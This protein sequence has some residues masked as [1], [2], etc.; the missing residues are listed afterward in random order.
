MANAT[1][2]V[3]RVGTMNGSTLYAVVQRGGQYTSP[4]VVGPAYDSRERADERLGEVV[5][6]HRAAKIAREDGRG[7]K[8]CGRFS[9]ALYRDGRCGA[10]CNEQ[11]ATS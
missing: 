1:F 10:C 2:T 7:C 8:V 11:G 9:W 4:T 5:L 3:E 6:A